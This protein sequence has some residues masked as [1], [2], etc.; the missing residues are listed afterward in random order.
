VKTLA[1]IPVQTRPFGPRALALA[2]AVSLSV[3]TACGGKSTPGAAKAAPARVENA[4][5]E[6]DLATITLT[7]EAETRLGVQTALAERTPVTRTRTLAGEVVV[8]PDSV[9]TVSA[10][11]AG[12]VLAVGTGAI[13]EVGTFVRKGQPV[14][15]LL[16]YV[17]PERDL[18]VQIEREIAS[19]ETR[20]EAAKVRL[21]R[22]EQLVRDKAGPQKSVDQARE[23]LALA[24]A[25]VKAGGQ[26][27]AKLAAA[28][29]SADV[30]MAVQAPRDGIVQRVHVGPGQAVASAAVLFEVA[31]LS[32]VWIRVPVYVGDVGTI[33]R[34]QSARIHG[35]ND[36]PGGPARIARPV[37]APPSADPAAATADLYYELQNGDGQL[38]PGQKVGVTLTTQVKE[39][40]L[41]VPWSA[42]LHDIHGG[43]WLYENTAPQVYV[44]R[45]IEVRTVVDDLAVLERGPA[46]GTR[47]VSVGAAEL[48][49]TEF[50]PG[51]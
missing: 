30:A 25:D 14:F 22:A 5:K 24:Q 48:F 1:E 18:R 49:G 28:P 46:P 38:R 35:L 33:R 9:M 19:G 12:T 3:V 21:A 11:I 2:L 34:G 29:L 40:S 47:V 20:V 4:P 36:A 39:E 27:L 31:N 44:R 8:P 10:P 23:E 15:R 17:A 41:V 37:A 16:P 51:K 50:G 45:P 26:R 6:G 7:P 42:V 32:T 43:T 13:P